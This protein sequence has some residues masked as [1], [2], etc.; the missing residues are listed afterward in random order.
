MK[1]LILIVLCAFSI[2]MCKETD[3]EVQA[4]YDDVM[5]VHDKVMPETSTIHQLKKKLKKLDVQ[6]STHMRLIYELDAAD[7]AMMEWMADF[8][9]FK[10][11]ADAKKDE[12]LQYLHNEY[13]LINDVSDKMYSAIDGAQMYLDSLSKLN[14]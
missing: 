12:K 4:L 3:P 2:I 5:E 10:K 1:Y 14:K 9:A 13:T 8:S 7:E 6:D 11:L